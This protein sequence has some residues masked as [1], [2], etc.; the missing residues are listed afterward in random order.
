MWTDFSVWWAE[1]IFS[2]SPVVPQTE[3]EVRPVWCVF[4]ELYE[5]SNSLS[6]DLK[7]KESKSWTKGCE[8][9]SG[10]SENKYK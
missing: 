1:D 3:A 8:T 4:D 5:M 7:R 6:S 9:V 2:C 10:P